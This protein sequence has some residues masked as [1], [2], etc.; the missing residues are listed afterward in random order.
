MNP[1]FGG[2]YPHAY[3]AGVNFMDAIVQ[4]LQGKVLK[5]ELG[6]YREGLIMMKYNGLAFMDESELLKRE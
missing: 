6:Q 5:P 1:R 4:N 2:G 3:N